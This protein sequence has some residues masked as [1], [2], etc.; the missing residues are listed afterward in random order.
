[1]I[2]AA[3][4]MGVYNLGLQEVNASLATGTIGVICKDILGPVGG[5]IALLGVIVLPITSGDTA[6]R[7]LRLVCFCRPVHRPELQGQAPGPVRHH[8]RAGGGDSGLCEEQPRWIQSAV[9][10]LRMVQPDPVPVRI[11]GYLRMDVREQ[12]GQVGVDPPDSRCLVHLCYSDLHCQCTDRLPYSLDA[13]YI[14]GVCAAVAYVAIIVW[15][16]KKRAARLQKL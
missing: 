13:A 9:A 4:A 12:Q 10:L 11:P 16:G 8:L 2:W 14:I 6:L 15:Y 5:I 7:S 3:A 1:M